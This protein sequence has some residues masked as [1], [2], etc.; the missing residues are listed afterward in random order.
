MEQPYVKWVPSIA[1]S[2][3]TKYTGD[4]YTGWKGDLIIGAMEGPAGLKLVRIDLDAD[5]NIVGEHHYLEDADRPYRDVVQGPDGYIYLLTKE[6]DGGV[7]RLD[8][9]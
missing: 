7:Y 2:G 6:L 4:K 8:V 3:M 1:P 9:N 5:G